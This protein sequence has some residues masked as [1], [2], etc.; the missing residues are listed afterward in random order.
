MAQRQ[1]ALIGRV[2]AGAQSI[3]LICSVHADL[4]FSTSHAKKKFFLE[5]R[6]D[7]V[8]RGAPNPKLNCLERAL[9]PRCPQ[10]SSDIDQGSRGGGQ[11][12][13]LNGVMRFELQLEESFDRR[14]T[15]S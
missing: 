13:C 1:A 9:V 3:F 12:R 4:P 8:L 6:F 5:M 10:D 14:S 2:A 7:W 11:V 15:T